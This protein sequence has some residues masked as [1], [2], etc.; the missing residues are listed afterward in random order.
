MPSPL[1]CPELQRWKGKGIPV[2]EQR[3]RRE[4]RIKHAVRGRSLPVF[5]SSPAS[6]SLKS[7]A[8]A[9]PA[10]SAAFCFCPRNE[11]MGK[12]HVRKSQAETRNG[13]RDLFATQLV[14][15]CHLWVVQIVRKVWSLPSD[16][17]CCWLGINLELFCL[18]SWSCCYFSV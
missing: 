13:M 10:S 14:Y 15:V 5:F 1:L 4:G 2:A 3:R 17:R 6:Q 11:A 7:R 16:S 12:L 18:I 8:I 9:P